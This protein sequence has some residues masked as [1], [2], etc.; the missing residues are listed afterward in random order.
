MQKYGL[1]VIRPLFVSAKDGTGI[2]TII[3]QM[4]QYVAIE[5]MVEKPLPLD[6][7][8]ISS[9]TPCSC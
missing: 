9:E 8:S 5:E 3:T 7:P 6:T 4:L 2:D 1:G